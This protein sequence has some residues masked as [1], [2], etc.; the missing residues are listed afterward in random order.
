MPAIG[1][2]EWK[3]ITEVIS[4]GVE[5]CERRSGPAIR[6][7]PHQR[8]RGFCEDDYAVAVPRTSNHGARRVAQDLRRTARNADLL[9]FSIGSK[10]HEP[11][12]GRPE[13]RRKS[14]W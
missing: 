1:K 7:D 9:E 8:A 13:K 10:H 12:V 11:A 4:Q 2:E 6:G 3:G 5:S 14:T